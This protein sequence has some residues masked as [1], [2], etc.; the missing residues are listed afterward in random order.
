MP[1]DAYFKALEDWQKEMDEAQ[2]GLKPC[3][4]CGREANIFP[5]GNGEFFA[6]C[7]DRFFGCHVESS[8]WPAS[9]IASAVSMWNERPEDDRIANLEAQR[10][11]LF[12][13]NKALYRQ[14][15][16]MQKRLDGAGAEEK[17]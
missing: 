10:D 8:T 9:D 16:A 7:G 2:P 14:L 3:P 6:G 12:N 17:H 1:N 13:E 15:V 5:T 4:F 11:G